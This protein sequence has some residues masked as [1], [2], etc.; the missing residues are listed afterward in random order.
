MK[1]NDRVLNTCMKFIKFD[2]LM[3]GL[4]EKNL[5]ITNRKRTTLLSCMLN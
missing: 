5:S 1:G 2:S 4:S 3:N